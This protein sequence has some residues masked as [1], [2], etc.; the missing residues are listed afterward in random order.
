MYGLDLTGE[1]RE[2]YEKSHTGT[3]TKRGGAGAS[4]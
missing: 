4:E 2:G 1:A 3:N